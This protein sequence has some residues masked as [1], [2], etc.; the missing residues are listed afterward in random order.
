MNMETL[1]NHMTINRLWH[2]KNKMP[3]NPRI[4]QRIEWHIGH[5]KTA[6]ICPYLK[7]CM[8]K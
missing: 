8:K 1:N 2:K 6:L 5:Q 7:N 4:D 3:K